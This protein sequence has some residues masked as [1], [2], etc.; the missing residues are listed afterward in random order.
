MSEIRKGLEK[1]FE[2]TT[3]VDGL[4]DIFKDA[5]KNY[6]SNEKE[7][8][9][10]KNGIKKFE[11]YLAP[12]RFLVRTDNKNFTSFLKRKLDRSIS[13]GR[14]LRGQLWF[15]QFEFDTEHIAGTK[16]CLPDTLTQELVYASYYSL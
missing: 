12:K 4:N 15:N 8:L 11:I 9:A 7:F 3:D 5:E 16:N 13:R 6:H 10:V 2:V 14:L 1:E